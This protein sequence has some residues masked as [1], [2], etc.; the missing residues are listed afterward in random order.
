MCNNQGEP[1][2]HVTAVI[3]TCTY[4]FLKDCC[5]LSIW[6]FCWGRR[7]INWKHANMVLHCPYHLTFNTVLRFVSFHCHSEETVSSM[8]RM[9]THWFLCQADRHTTRISKGTD[10]LCVLFIQ[11]FVAHP[12]TC[13][14]APY[15]VSCIAATLVSWLAGHAL[16]CMWTWHVVGLVMRLTGCWCDWQLWL[17]CDLDGCITIDAWLSLCSVL[18]VHAWLPKLCVMELWLIALMSRDLH[19]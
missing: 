14:A 5:P 19:F 10:Y 13:R 3:W 6:I 7:F 9:V 11:V 18:L 15:N 16:N 4:L 2:L 12:T 1:G 8:S 17:S